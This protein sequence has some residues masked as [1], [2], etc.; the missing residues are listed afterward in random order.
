MEKI[1]VVHC[2][3]QA[4]FRRGVFE[5]LQKYDDIELIGEAVHG[6][7]LLNKLE[8]L[9]PDVIILN[10]MMPVMSGMETLPI[11][12]EKFPHIKVF[13]LSLVDDPSMVCMAIERGANGYVCKVSE[14]EE[15]YRAIRV[16]YKKWF[17]IN[18]L[19]SDAFKWK[20]EKDEKKKLKDAGLD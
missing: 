13:V 18:D 12:R 10:M 20:L 15:V 14:L 8:N 7:D 3:D 9:T 17:Y 1:K 16:C 5:S 19:V 2:D 4:V 6:L 11:L